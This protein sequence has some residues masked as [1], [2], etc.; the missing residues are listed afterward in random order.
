[1]VSYPGTMFK[2]RFDFILSLLL[3]TSSRID[4]NLSSAPTTSATTKIY[5]NNQIGRD[6][7]TC[8]NRTN[9]CKTL[10]YAWQKMLEMNATDSVHFSLTSPG[11]YEPTI[12]T[13]PSSLFFN[14][15]QNRIK[16]ISIQAENDSSTIH[17]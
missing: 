12:Q 13:G 1:M 7:V 16:D 2:F 11:F 15:G 9:P 8:Q 17:R 14:C 4:A 6:S 3:V 5:I 10:W